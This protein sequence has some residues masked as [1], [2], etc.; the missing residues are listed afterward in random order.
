[1][2][3]VCLA[4]DVSLFE[5][6]ISDLFPGVK[7][8]KLDLGVFTQALHV[9]I[10]KHKLQPVPWFMDKIVQVFEKK[11]NYAFMVSI[12]FQVNNCSF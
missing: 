11:L 9:Q 12:L 2:T 7:L 10:A 8:P 6:I 3:G 1:M 4:Q 5:G